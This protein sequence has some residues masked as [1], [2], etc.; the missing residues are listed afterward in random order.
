MWQFRRLPVL[1]VIRATICVAGEGL[2][3][4]IGLLGSVG[5]WA[6]AQLTVELGHDGGPPPRLG[7]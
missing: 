1:C 3:L 6:V 7:G 2:V 5:A 4:A